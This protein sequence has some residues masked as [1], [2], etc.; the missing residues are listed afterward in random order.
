MSGVLITLFFLVVVVYASQQEDPLSEVE[1]RKSAYMRFGRIDPE[2]YGDEMPMEKRKSAYMR[3]G[4]RSEAADDLDIEKRKSAYMR[5]GKRKSAYMSLYVKFYH[6]KSKG[7]YIRFGKRSMEFDEA[8]EPV[9]MEKRKSAYMR[10]VFLLD[11]YLRKMK[12]FIF[13]FGR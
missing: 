9:D 3:F 13:R 8:L 6:L 10:L 7:Y 1:K 11:K 12:I 5:F 4:K 2:L